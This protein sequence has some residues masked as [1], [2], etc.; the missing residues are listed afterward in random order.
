MT[1]ADSLSYLNESASTFPTSGMTRGTR[2][3]I[4]VMFPSCLTDLI[5]LLMSRGGGWSSVDLTLL[6]SRFSRSLEESFG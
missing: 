4:H 6:G 3:G 1:R 5:D 2:V